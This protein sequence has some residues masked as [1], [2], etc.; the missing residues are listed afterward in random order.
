MRVD[1]G[2]QRTNASFFHVLYIGFQQKAWPRLRWVFPLQKVWS[3]GESK[4][5][6]RVPVQG[7]ALKTVAGLMLALGLRSV[8]WV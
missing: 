6:I 2:R 1:A 4:I 8:S 7:A 5:Q 3:K